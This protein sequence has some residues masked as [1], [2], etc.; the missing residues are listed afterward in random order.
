MRLHFDEEQMPDAVTTI[1]PLATD[2]DGVVATLASGV[3][4]GDAVLR[5]TATVCSGLH[6]RRANLLAVQEVSQDV[7][8][9]VVYCQIEPSGASDN[10]QTN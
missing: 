9:V 2:L 4:R 10:G 6:C 1:S 5:E 7:C 8:V 3:R